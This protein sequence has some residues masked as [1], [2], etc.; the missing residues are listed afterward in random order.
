MAYATLD[1]VIALYRELTENEE[2]KVEALLPIIDDLINQEAMNRGYS[3]ED[4]LASGKLLRN[5]LIA[6]EVD[7]VKRAITQSDE[8][9]GMSQ[10]S[11]SL[12][13]YSFSG[14]F[15]NNGVYLLNNEIKR[16]GLRKQRMG[17]IELC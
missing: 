14:T 10:F 7:V 12:S 11:E 9:L 8:S 4:M 1:D 6:V 3:I 15:I 16:L 13:G 17:T 5:V 2:S